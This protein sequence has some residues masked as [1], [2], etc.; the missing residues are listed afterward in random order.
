MT[1]FGNPQ[2]LRTI[3][4]TNFFMDATFKVKPQTTKTDQFFSIL[5][6]IDDTVNL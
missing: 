2:F 5:A 6:L 1:T 3:R 4:A